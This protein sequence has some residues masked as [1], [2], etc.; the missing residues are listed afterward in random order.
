MYAA[1]SGHRESGK[2][3]AI[4]LKETVVSET[5]HTTVVEEPQGTK[6]KHK[7]RLCHML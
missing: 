2:E 7:G 3:K 1:P 5:N 6:A 4:V